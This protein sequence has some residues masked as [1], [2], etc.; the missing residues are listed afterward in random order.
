MS[1]ADWSVF[2]T[3]V[4]KSWRVATR[5]GVRGSSLFGVPILLALVDSDVMT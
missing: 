2:R 4:L 5:P 3:F 1:N